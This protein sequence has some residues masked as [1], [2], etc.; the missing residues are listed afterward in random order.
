MPTPDPKVRAMEKI[1]ARDLHSIGLSVDEAIG[2]NATNQIT[3]SALRDIRSAIDDLA[4]KLRDLGKSSDLLT[5]RESEILI[6]LGSGKTAAAIGI[7][8]SISEPTVKSHMA[9]IYRKLNVS[10]KTSA[11]AEARRLGLLSK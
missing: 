6:S 4:I 7:D 9:S 2:R 10:N 5:K 8:Y 1:V 3:R 11:L